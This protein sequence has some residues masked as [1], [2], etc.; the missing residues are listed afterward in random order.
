MATY[1]VTSPDGQKYEINAPDGA[2]EKE[3][4]SYAQQNFQKPATA[5][6][7]QQASIPRRI[8]QGMR[9]PVDAGAQLLTKMLPESVV[10]AGNAANNWLAENTGLVGALP[11]GG[12][13]QQIREGEQQY[14]ESRA[15]T[16]NAGVDWARL[17]GNIASPM[18]LAIA[19]KVPVGASLLGRVGTGAAGGGIMGA[20][21]PV[22]EGDFA[23]E[24]AKQ[25]GLGAAVGGALPLV[26]G[27]VSRMVSPK[28]S[29]QVQ[30][31]LDEGVTPTPGQI[32]GGGWQATED[33]LTSVPILG[34]AISS[35]RR[36]G[37]D[38]FNRAGYKRSLDAIGGTVPKEVG[39]EGV[40]AVDDQI[41]K[42]YNNLL[43]K[44][45]F[46]AD[47][48]FA[49]DI[50]KLSSM[51][52][53]LPED[54]A[55]RFEKILRTQVIG[56]L[57]PRGTMDGETMKGVESELGRL[58]RGLMGDAS[59][60]NRELG[61]AVGEIQSAM[62]SSLSRT[63]PAHADELKAINTAFANFA[64]VRD[65]ASRQGSLEG[66]FTP[67]Q[68]SAAVRSGD[69]SVGHKAFAKG[70]AL[71]Q[72]LSDAGKGVLASRYPDSGT[73]GRALLGAGA[74]GAVGGGSLLAPTAGVPAAAAG[75]FSLLPYLPG[76]RQA[77]AAILARRPDAAKS[78]A[79]V[80][81]KS[82]PFLAPGAMPLLQ[83]RE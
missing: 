78:V 53:A 57:G 26:T 74:A 38:E 76:G 66:K 4:L 48:T 43:P 15:A 70:D 73:A 32:L 12:V 11:P 77:A 72:D 27:A 49:A 13:D 22:T 40:A 67:G 51:A 31:L 2:S 25:V 9:D 34:D 55:N 58:A 65:A 30:S 6:Q 81:K 10:N 47:N 28:S 24:K 20:L 42:A 64:R 1:E 50:N 71:L 19:S 80:I 8:L 18:N 62:R 82:G 16:G 69:K 44:V 46:Q 41:S 5:E 23:K 52:S 56:K 33:K 3:I 63:N 59:F 79:E 75:L 39:R 83:S 7:K 60:D 68:L 36:K 54:Q 45:T 61:K 21:S 35:A 14:Q 37:L 29:P 17:G